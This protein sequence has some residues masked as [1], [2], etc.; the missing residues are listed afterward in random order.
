[1]NR[2]FWSGEHRNLL[3]TKSSKNFNQKACEKISLKPT[4]KTSTIKEKYLVPKIPVKIEMNHQINFKVNSPYNL[5]QSQQS[6]I[7]SRIP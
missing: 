5:V 1:M 3:K 2:N 4:P 6:Y 7:S